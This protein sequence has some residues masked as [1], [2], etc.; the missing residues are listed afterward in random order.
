MRARLTLRVFL[1]NNIM[2]R[3]IKKLN[4]KESIKGLE[5]DSIHLYVL[6][7][8]IGVKYVG[9]TKD[10]PQ[11]KIRHQSKMLYN[12]LYF[13]VIGS[14]FDRGLAEFFEITLI[15]ELESCGVELL[16]IVNDFTE[17]NNKQS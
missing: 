3:T 12:D 15:K 14:F 10:L 16:N 6:E 5:M 11:T 8:E 13:K 9:V 4:V 1:Y 2:K 7:N 17:S